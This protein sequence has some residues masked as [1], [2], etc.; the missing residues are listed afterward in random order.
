MMKL[1][2]AVVV[3]QLEVR[4]FLAATIHPPV[5]RVDL[6]Q[7]IFQQQLDPFFRSRR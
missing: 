3:N 1:P 2:V 6:P 4:Q 5:N 7:L